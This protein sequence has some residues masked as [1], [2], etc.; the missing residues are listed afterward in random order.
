MDSTITLVGN[1]TR[2]PVL[3][4]TAGGVPVADLGLAVH[5]RWRQGDE[6]QEHT[7]FFTVVAWRALAENCVSSLHR[8]DL[9]V[10]QGRLE[11]RSWTTDTGDRRSVS[12]V[13]ANDVG[14]S[15]R[16]A[17]VELARRPGPDRSGAE[18]PPV[19]MAA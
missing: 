14:P 11:Q 18:R 15:L 13:I 9:V 12:E 19:S 10:V 4:T 7:S 3:R 5:R 2:D 16:W 1:L 8:G 6:W 17:T